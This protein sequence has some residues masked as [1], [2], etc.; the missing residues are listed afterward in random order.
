VKRTEGVAAVA[1]RVDVVVPTIATEVSRSRAA[2]L[3]RDGRVRVDGRIVRRPSEPVS[4]GARVSIEMPD[5][6]PASATAQDL[7]I[8]V[9]YEDSDV[10]VVDKAAGMVVHPGAGHADGT[11]VNALLFHTDDLSGV[12]GE[13]RP[14]IVH[15]LDRGTSGLMVVAKNDVA[16]RALA[17]QFATHEAG[18]TYLALCLGAPRADSGTIRSKLARHP[19]DRKKFAS[20][21]RGK[22][23]ITHWR[24]LAHGGGTSLVE[25]RL[26]T[27]RTHQVR[28]HLSEAGWP[29]VG[30]P[31]YGPRPARLPPK[32]R[33]VV[34]PDRPLLH[35]HQLRFRHPDGRAMTFE[36]PLP[37]DFVTAVD[38]AGLHPG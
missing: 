22:E 30:D 36:S 23:A 10:V 21:E 11:L 3:V 12:G 25:C 13:A 27:G 26:E 16:H 20:G 24:A 2:A 32:L 34:D 29:I 6:V 35:A 37:D 9:V 28:V 1:A 31:L 8:R 4:L 18:R 17:A 38:A 14:G 15:R 19:R 33:A 7:P 5:L